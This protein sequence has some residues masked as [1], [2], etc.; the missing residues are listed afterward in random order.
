M[1]VE[2]GYGEWNWNPLMWVEGQSGSLDDRCPVGL[3]FP[4]GTKLR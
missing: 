3:Q 1:V 4:M 2:V